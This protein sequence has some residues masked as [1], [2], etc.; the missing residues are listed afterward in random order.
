VAA[1]RRRRYHDAMCRSQYLVVIFLCAAAGCSGPR[2]PD[3]PVAL[4]SRGMIDDVLT[5]LD[6]ARR[7]FPDDAEIQSLWQML[8]R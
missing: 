1:D 7:D 3:L 8:R 6:R 2:E 5:V 4:N